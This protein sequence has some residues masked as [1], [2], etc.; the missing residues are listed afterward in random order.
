MKV[1]PVLAIAA[2]LLFA[3]GA[4]AQPTNSKPAPV[5]KPAPTTTPAPAPQ[6]KTEQPKAEQPKAET[7]KVEKVSW[8]ELKTNMG[9]IVIEVDGEKAPISAANFLTYVSEGFY[10][11]TAF[12]RVIKDFMIQGGGFT[13]SGTNPDVSEKKPT[14]GQIKNEWQNGLKN[15]KYTVSMAR[16]AV[17]DSATSQ[18]FINASDKNSFLD[19]PRDGAGY[20]VFGKVVAGM[21]VV[22]KIAAV[23]TGTHPM[24]DVPDSP[25]V[26]EKARKLS[27]DEAKKL[28]KED[29]PAETKPAES[30]P[31]PAPAPTPAP[32]PAPKP[33]PAP[34]T[35]PAPAPTTPPKGP[36]R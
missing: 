24:R 17:A 15:R 26:I 23:K 11:N 35:S 29:K 34:S 14:H 18:F 25:V 33:A 8:V 3:A 31:A 30:K 21:D 6:P 9:N 32:A 5:V 2:A 10:D 12:H 22:D 1:S 7:P 20:A 4:L 28:P 27:E 36:G 16:T 13:V 19:Q